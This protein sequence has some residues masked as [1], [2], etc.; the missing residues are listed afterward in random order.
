[1]LTKHHFILIHESTLQPPKQAFLWSPHFTD[2]E[3]EAQ[4]GE[5]TCLGIYS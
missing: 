5:I 3:T 2:G 4:S 1:M